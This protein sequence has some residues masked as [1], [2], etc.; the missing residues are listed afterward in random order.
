[1]E[2][3][4]TPTRNQSKAWIIVVIV[5]ALLFTCLVAGLI[6]GIVGYVAGRSVARVEPTPLEFRVE[7]I[8]E[9]IPIPEMP[10]MVSGWALVVSVIE[11]SPADRAGLRVGDLITSVHGEPLSDAVSLADLIQPYR[12]GDE[13]ELD[14]LRG[15]R[16]R[17]ITVTLG[18]S[19]RERNM[20]WL[21]IEYRQIPAGLDMRFE[22]PPMRD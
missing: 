12:P 10:G 13:I 15:G 20:P 17:I 1:M 7:P 6:G 19:P 5:V 2:G 11:D 4:P 14:V 8:P 22:L 9:R 21:G 16:E 3:K 18:R